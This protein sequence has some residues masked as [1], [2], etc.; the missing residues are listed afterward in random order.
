[1]PKY[2]ITFGDTWKKGSF[3][4]DEIAA[5]KAIKADSADNDEDLN[6]LAECFIKQLAGYHELISVKLEWIYNRSYHETFFGYSRENVDVGVT[7]MYYDYIGGKDVI[8][9][10]FATFTEI[11]SLT[12]DDDVKKIGRI[13]RYAEVT[14]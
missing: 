13:T 6:A 5:I 7:V 2:N 12:C 14:E 10:H 11:N 1:M 8:T 9:K 3:T 4:L